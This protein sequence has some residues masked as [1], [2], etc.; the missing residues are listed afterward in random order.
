[1]MNARITLLVCGGLWA[2]LMLG[3]SDAVQ[4][5]SLEAP[6]PLNKFDDAKVQRIYDLADRR[7]ADSLLPYLSDSLGSIRREA[8]LVFGSVQD[9]RALPQLMTLL[10]DADP[11]IVTASAWAIG[12]I[13]DST[14]APALLT[15][16]QKTK[17]EAQIAVGEALGKTGS[18]AEI[19][20]AIDL[21]NTKALPAAA[22]NALAQAVYRAGLRKRVPTSA[23]ALMLDMLA[24]PDEAAQL[25]AAAFLGRVA[26]SGPIS[27]P[28][29]L[30]GPMR[31][32]QSADVRQ[33]L[34]RAFARCQ[35]TA[36]T[37][38]LQAIVLDSAEA[39][40]VRANGFR[41][42]GG[43]HKLQAQAQLA[44][45]SPVEMVAVAAAEYLDQAHQGLPTELLQLVHGVGAWRPRAILLKTAMREAV[46]KGGADIALVTQYIDSLMPHAAL[47][48]QAALYTALGQSPAQHKR[49][50][51][52]A[53]KREPVL[54]TYAFEA[55]LGYFQKPM[56][57]NRGIIQAIAQVMGSGDAGLV[58]MGAEHIAGADLGFVAQ[59]TKPD[60]LD[61]ALQ[62]LHLPEDIEA[63]NAVLKATAKV[64]S[65]SYEAH[66]LGF[67]HPIDWAL[68][69]NIPTNQ[70]VSIVTNRGNITLRLM[71]EDAPGTVANFVKLVQ[72]GFF[73]GKRIHRMVPAFVA[74]GGCPRGDG[75]GSSPETI[76]S[77]WAPLHYKPG[78]VG[79]A[80]A[81]KD[82][83]SCQWFITHC[84]VPHLDGRYTIFAEVIAGMPVVD[85]LEIGDE[86][87]RIS[88]PGFSA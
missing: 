29:R 50:I 8:A 72:D 32:L 40:A 82:T 66:V 28:E 19:T 7:E 31:N 49:L 54:S 78:A 57:D 62:K 15:A 21:Y 3:C 16:L 37:R 84:A 12:Q 63:Y 51:D 17:G 75:W 9:A 64:R 25:Y 38:R 36:C 48:E 30:L 13:G 81:G 68:V 85:L 24:Q 73:N 45:A 2:M 22:A 46:A 4:P 55:Y 76:R 80:S 59:I 11:K 60:F 27:A 71:V 20:A 35:D 87:I 69:R 44:V 58:A 26:E 52:L 88:L 86:I 47:Y 53:I 83:E 79:M 1:M 33:Q 74:Q 10:Q 39:P 18:L 34:V 67:Q 65:R 42:T 61:S 6:L 70:T 5:T 77:E 14:A 41:A 23:Q 43:Y 56:R